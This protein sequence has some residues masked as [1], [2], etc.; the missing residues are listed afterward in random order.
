M[1][2]VHESNANPNCMR[3]TRRVIRPP[4]QHTPP[5]EPPPTAHAP[6]QRRNIALA[7]YPFTYGVKGRAIF[8]DSPGDVIRN[9][10]EHI[11]V[12]PRVQYTNGTLYESD[13][14]TTSAALH[15]EHGTTG[16]AM[17]LAEKGVPNGGE[18]R[19]MVDFF[20]EMERNQQMQHVTV[21]RAQAPP[22]VL[23]DV[24]RLHR[25]LDTVGAREQAGKQ[26]LRSDAKSGET[27]Y[28]LRG[29]S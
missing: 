8:P 24:P 19:W 22:R 20:S 28:P 1:V 7:Y 27:A 25:A 5:Y 29:A 15:R 10:R 23:D 16:Q 13:H 14:A 4:A 6:C 17:C 12:T 11:V 3:D 9:T 21:H 18:R 2:S 26:D